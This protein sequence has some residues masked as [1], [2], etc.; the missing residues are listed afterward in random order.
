M[1]VLLALLP[2]QACVAPLLHKKTAER[3]A[4]I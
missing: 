3:A 2:S 4:A 1:R